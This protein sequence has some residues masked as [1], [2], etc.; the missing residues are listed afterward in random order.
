MICLTK[1]NI[2]IKS[3][4]NFELTIIDYLMDIIE[5]SWIINVIRCIYRH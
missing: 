4:H 5:C 1:T 2:P 3:N